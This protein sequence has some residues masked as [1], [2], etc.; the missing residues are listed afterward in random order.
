MREIRTSGAMREGVAGLPT[1]PLYS[2]VSNTPPKPP[3]PF[4]EVFERSG[5]VDATLESSLLLTLA[6]LS[7]R[8]CFLSVRVPRRMLVAT[9][10]APISCSTSSVS[11]TH[12]TLPTR[13]CQCRSRWSA[14]E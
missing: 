5:N 11:Y 13:S 2:T 8:L 1:R 9:R 4:H 3:L 12:L 6:I 7:L 14:G 10:G